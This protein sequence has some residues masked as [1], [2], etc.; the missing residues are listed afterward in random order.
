[1]F[2]GCHAKR[3]L[4]LSD[5]SPHGK[6]LIDFCKSPKYEISIK[7]VRWEPLHFMRTDGRTRQR[8]WCIFA[9]AIRTC[10]KRLLITVHTGRSNLPYSVL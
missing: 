6:V 5:F 8:E 10:L 4:F 3:L 7:S 9:T 2:V 1:M